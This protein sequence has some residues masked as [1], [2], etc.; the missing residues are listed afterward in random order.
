[1]PRKVF[2]KR[3]V[4]GIKKNL[5]SNFDHRVFIPFLG[6]SEKSEFNFALRIFLTLRSFRIVKFKDTRYKT[7]VIIYINLDIDRR[8][9]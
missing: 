5:I 4:N 7:I 6:I 2:F 1:M 9:R 8:I 3:I